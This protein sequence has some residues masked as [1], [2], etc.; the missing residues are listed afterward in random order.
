[1]DPVKKKYYYYTSDSFNK[2]EISSV[3]AFNKKDVK[4]YLKERNIRCCGIWTENEDRFP[5]GIE[6]LTLYPRF[7]LKKDSDSEI[8]YS[9]ISANN[10]WVLIVCLSL[11]C[12]FIIWSDKIALPS[13]L[14]I[15][16]GVALIITGVILF[17]VTVEMKI[18][19]NT[20]DIIEKLKVMF[21]TVKTKITH[22]N[23]FDKI[24]VK[25]E[26]INISGTE[27]FYYFVYLEN[28]TNRILVDM[29]DNYKFESDL[30]IR[31]SRLFNI[32]LD[33]K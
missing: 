6:H 17:S 13:Y 20:R 2:L 18:D 3:E 32:E 11:G 7:R 23:G 15:L 31:L 22:T 26:M 5:S 24:S 1:M 30:A 19:G 12:P 28:G 27:N 21:F 8:V 33:L 16:L 4:R 25:K 14:N 29:S 10:I 9:G